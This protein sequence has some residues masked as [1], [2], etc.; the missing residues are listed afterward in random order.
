MMNYT[1]PRFCA[2]VLFSAVLAAGWCQPVLSA[3]VEGTDASLHLVSGTLLKLDLTAG[4]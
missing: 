4:R 2:A 1:S 3:G